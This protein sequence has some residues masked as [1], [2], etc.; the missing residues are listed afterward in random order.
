MR[1]VGEDHK[2]LPFINTEKVISLATLFPLTPRIKE[3]L[4]LK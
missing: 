4:Q 2:S 1:R 3:Y